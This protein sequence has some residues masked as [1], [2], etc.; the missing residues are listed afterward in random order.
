MINLYFTYNKVKNKTFLR[1]CFSGYYCYSNCCR[2]EEESIKY[3]EKYFKHKNIFETI[4]SDSSVERS[5]IQK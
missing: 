3:L 5:L 2:S 4:K 1:R